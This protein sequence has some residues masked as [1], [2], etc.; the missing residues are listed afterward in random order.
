MRRGIGREEEGRED[1]AQIAEREGDVIHA[2]L[3]SPAFQLLCKWA[4]GLVGQ[5]VRR[6]ICAGDVTAELC[7]HESHGFFISWNF[8]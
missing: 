4:I 3:E 2:A 8:V 7:H 6:D 1:A 5:D